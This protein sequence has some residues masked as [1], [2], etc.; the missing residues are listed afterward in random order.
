MVGG[1]AAA[2]RGVKRGSVALSG[3]VTEAE[4]AEACQGADYSSLAKLYT[5]VTTLLTFL[6]Q[7]LGADGSCQQ[8]V[9]GLIAERTAASKS[10]CSADTGGYCK[11]RKRLPEAVPWQ[12]MRNAGRNVEQQ[13]RQTNVAEQATSLAL[14]GR[15][16]RVVD[17]STNK[18][19]DTE[20]NRAEYPLMRGLEPG[21]HYPIVRFLVIFSLAVG[22]VLDAAIRPYQG[23][24]TGETAMLRELAHVFEPGDVLLGDRYFAG[25]WDIAFWLQRG[26]DVVSRLPASR[27]FDHR[28]GK[29]LG[30][31]DYL[32]TWEKTQRPAWVEVEAAGNY[33]ETLLIRVIKITVPT[34][35]FRVKQLWVIT[36][37]LEP[38]Q[39]P[40]SE[41]AD[42]YRRRWQAEL[43]IRSLKTHLGL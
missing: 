31:N 24:G 39:Y 16:V 5:P 18:I 38:E 36:T 40:A 20:A 2:M 23:K 42:L 3:L 35:G 33:P 26:V 29:R 41:I 27:P 32:M 30:P 28:R 11:A 22:T 1:F 34:R 6:A 43:N 15:S 9:N 19:A 17:G 10:K 25:Y 14:R 7:L 37:L 8:A 13:A 4:V 21:L 12:L